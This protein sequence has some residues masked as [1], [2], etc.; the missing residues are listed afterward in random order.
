MPPHI[1]L[2]F[3][4]E[5]TSFTNYPSSHAMM[6]LEH[7]FD[8][9]VL[10]ARSKDI[11]QIQKTIVELSSMFGKLANIVSSQNEMVRRID[12]NI[13]DFQLNVEAGHLELLKYFRS[14]S[15]NRWLMFKLFSLLFVF[16][17]IFIWII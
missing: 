15:S 9:S 17:V 4:E 11:H 6:K 8:S 14:I 10:E 12:A 3:N 5:D 1:T 13:E 16:L 2:E 7:S